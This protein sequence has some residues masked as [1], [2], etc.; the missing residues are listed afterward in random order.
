MP[1]AADGAGELGSADGASDGAADGAA[2]GA[3][4]GA[5]VGAADAAGALLAPEFEQAA[6]TAIRPIAERH[7][8]GFRVHPGGSSK[9]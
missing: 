5:A 4:D 7:E 2:E 9:G 1:V 8:A 6:R 3:T